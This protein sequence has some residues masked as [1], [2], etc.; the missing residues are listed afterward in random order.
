MYWLY[1]LNCYIY[2]KYKSL[3]VQKDMDKKGEKS[4]PKICMFHIR[5]S[6]DI[7]KIVHVQAAEADTTI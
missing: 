4:K 7:Q 2:S 3:T 6:E 5:L 1:S